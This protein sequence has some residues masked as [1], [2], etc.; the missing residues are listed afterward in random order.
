MLFC[1]VLKIIKILFQYIIIRRNSKDASLLFPF[2]FPSFGKS[3]GL[4]LPGVSIIHLNTFRNMWNL[5]DF[6][7]HELDHTEYDWNSK[8]GI[9]FFV[10]VNR[11]SF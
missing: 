7:K 5:H 11:I 10:I 3:T 2:L 4:R 6:W 1:K 9:F 8:F